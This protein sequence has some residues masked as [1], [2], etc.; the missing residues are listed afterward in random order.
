MPKD[1]CCQ[2]CLS[3]FTPHTAQHH[4]RTLTHSRAHAPGPA[5]A[6]ACTRAL[7]PALCTWLLLPQA[8]GVGGRP[9]KYAGMGDVCRQTLAKEGLAG[10]Y[11][12]ST[13]GSI[14]YCVTCAHA[15]AP[16]GV[17]AARVGWG[18]VRSQAGAPA[19]RACA[20]AACWLLHMLCTAACSSGALQSSRPPLVRPRGALSRAVMVTRVTLLSLPPPPVRLPSAGPAAQS[21]Q[22]CASRGH[23]LVRV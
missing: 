6:L 16:D 20:A 22:A 10:F 7:A 18:P 5:D 9:I 13:H 3:C 15:H 11:K 1:A 17:S 23:Q 4:A 8:Q 12:V 2:H 21:H 14:T 19:A